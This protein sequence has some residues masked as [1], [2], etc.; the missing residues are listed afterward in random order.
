MGH[1]LTPKAVIFFDGF[2]NLCNSSVQFIIIRDKKGIFKYAS[3]QSLVAEELLKPFS[4]EKPFPD[5]IL[6]LYENRLYTKSRAI[7]KIC[8][9]LGF[10]YSLL[11]FFKILPT[12]LLNWVYDFIAKIRYK[13]FGKRE[14]CMLPK[15]EWQDRFLS[16]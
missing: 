13:V 5:S 10:P 7:I 11:L 6:L 1:P 15:P 4:S 8:G 3:L 2:C 14:S 12:F 9:L 16:D